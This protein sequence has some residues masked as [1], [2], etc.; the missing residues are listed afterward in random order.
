MR[1]SSPTLE[2]YIFTDWVSVAQL[3]A[4]RRYF[5]LC[6]KTTTREIIIPRLHPAHLLV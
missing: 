2:K 4:K 6:V 5:F 1:K 3:Q